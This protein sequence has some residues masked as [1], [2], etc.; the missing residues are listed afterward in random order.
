MALA[1]ALVVLK[2]LVGSSLEDPTIIHDVS[3]SVN[4][5]RLNAKLASFMTSSIV[6]WFSELVVYKSQIGPGRKITLF[7][8]TT[9]RRSYVTLFHKNTGRRSYV[10]LYHKNTGRRSYVIFVS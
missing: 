7:R 1:S 3:I 8:K 10:T 5:W 2:S 9:G 4:C 6:D